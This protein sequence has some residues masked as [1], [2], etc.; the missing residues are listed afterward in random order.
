MPADELSRN[1]LIA[2]RDL[3]QSRQAQIRELQKLGWKVVPIPSLPDMYRTINYVNGIHDRT[4][5]LMP[6]QGGFYAFLDE[7]AGNAFKQ[8]LGP[9]IAIIPIFSAAS[10][11]NHGAVHCMASAYP[12]PAGAKN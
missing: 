8:A 10:Q 12:R 6:A 9:E 7:A 2:L 5:Y 11:R 3:E 4:R 1:Y